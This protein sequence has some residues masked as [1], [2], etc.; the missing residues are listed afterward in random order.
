M[1]QRKSYA[2]GL[3]ERMELAHCGSKTE[4]SAVRVG[5]QAIKTETASPLFLES[6][7]FIFAYST[8]LFTNYV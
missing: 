6:W 3:V 2:F 4:P 7:L 8:V 5:K 1:V